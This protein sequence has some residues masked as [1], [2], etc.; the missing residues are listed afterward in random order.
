MTARVLGWGS[1]YLCAFTLGPQA[2]ANV[3]DTYGQ[4]A[5]SVALGNA[6]VAGGPSAFAAYTNPAAL[7]NSNRS[8]LATSLLATQFRLKDIP[9]SPGG[10]LPPQSFDE[11]QAEAIQGVT[12]G[13]N[14]K[15]NSF[16][17]A[18]LAGYMPQGNFGRLRGLSPYQASYLSFSEQQQKPAIFTALAVKLPADFALGLGAYYSLRAKGVLQ[19]SLSNIESEGRFDLVMEPVVVPYGGVLW[20]P[21]DL[22]VKLGLTYR[23]AQET[24]SEIASA[25]AFSTEDA[26]LPFDA[27]T[28]LVP[29]YD[30]AMLRLGASWTSGASA[31]HVTLEQSQWSKFKA[32]L[33]TLSGSDVAALSQELNPAK[34]SGLKDALAYKVGASRSI[35]MGSDETLELRS[36][37]EFHSSA[38]E[39]GKSSSVIDPAR[40]TIAAGAAWTLAADQEGHRLSLEGALQHHQLSAIKT[41]SLKGTELSLKSGSSLQTVVGG[42]SYV[43]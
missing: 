14:L 25:F 10:K 32:P 1:F 7:T 22:P 8:E 26:L 43:L 28:S 40:W 31:L 19:V 15:L 30:P 16:V 6:I 39:S 23:A 2:S 27:T 13:I 17:H 12:L 20:S 35:P 21:Q 29:F 5:S 36:G 38:N 42:L 18:G 9:D 33:V 11:S 41:R 3:F 24:Q 4:G 37:L 34:N